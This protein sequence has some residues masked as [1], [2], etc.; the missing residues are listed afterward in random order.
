[1]SD[2]QIKD[3]EILVDGAIA[4]SGTVLTESAKAIATAKNIPYFMVE[5]LHMGD[6]D[7]T[8]GAGQGAIYGIRVTPNHKDDLIL[9]QVPNAWMNIFY[10][11]WKNGDKCSL[12]YRSWDRHGNGYA[13]LTDISVFAE[14]P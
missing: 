1:M 6:K 7:G 10:K 5:R 13:E 11:A 12:S 2:P 9:V 8:K 3:L 4:E 14:K